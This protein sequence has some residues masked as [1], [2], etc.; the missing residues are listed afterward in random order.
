VTLASQNIDVSFPARARISE[1]LGSDRRIDS[2]HISAFCKEKDRIHF[3]ML[4]RRGKARETAGRLPGLSANQDASSEVARRH[5]D[6]P[7]TLI[8]QRRNF[9]RDPMPIVTGD[10]TSSAITERRFTGDRHFV[11]RAYARR[12]RFRRRAAI[13]RARFGR[14]DESNCVPGFSRCFPRESFR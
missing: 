6:N 3:T 8:S 13:A 1:L 11:F 2:R 7:H 14:R 5:A 9:R 10:R 4:H 12:A